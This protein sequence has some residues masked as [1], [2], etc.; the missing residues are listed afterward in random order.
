MSW[1]RS[2]T[3]L[4]VFPIV[5]LVNFEKIMREDCE[6][7]PA[8]KIHMNKKFYYHA[9]YDRTTS[10][11]RFAGKHTNLEHIASVMSSLHRYPK[12]LF[13][14]LGWKPMLR[15]QCLRLLLDDLVQ[16]ILVQIPSVNCSGCPSLS[17]RALRCP[18]PLAAL[19]RTRGAP[20]CVVI[21]PGHTGTQITR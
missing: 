11:F 14:V 19:P 13:A 20:V 3:A 8:S 16:R 10:D 2:L 12:V 1:S 6:W 18:P 4:K 17:L 9:T 21:R 7:K 15:S 5:K